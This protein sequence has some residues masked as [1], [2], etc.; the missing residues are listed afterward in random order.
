MKK[1]IQKKLSK[2]YVKI[3]RTE[4]EYITRERDHTD[5][6]DADD[7]AWENTI[8][9]FEVVDK[10]GGWDF[11]L[12]ENPTGKTYYLV[13]ALYSTGDTFHHE[14]HRLCLVSMFAHMEDAK[15]VLKA[16]EKDYNSYD[17]YAAWNQVKPLS[18]V[19]PK[20][21]RTENIYTGTW[22]GYFERLEQVCIESIGSGNS[23]L[24]VTFNRW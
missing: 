23:K 8:R 16:I 9:G 6:W 15:A 18:V 13:Y 22:K 19:L 3:D 5:E 24:K 7:I 11:V 2:F 17:R 12:N 1:Y 20:D 21:G 14:E 4:R 10:H